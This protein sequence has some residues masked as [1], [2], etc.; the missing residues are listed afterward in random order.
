[1]DFFIEIKN[2][3]GER[4]SANVVHGDQRK[5]SIDSFLAVSLGRSISPTRSNR[6]LDKCH[7][8]DKR[9]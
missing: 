2:A 5:S 7:A 1:M 9:I 4:G 3:L 6:M 8:L